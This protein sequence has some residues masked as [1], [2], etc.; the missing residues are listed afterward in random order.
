MSNVLL[1]KKDELNHG[2]L[3]HNKIVCTFYRI[4]DYI[5]YKLFHRQAPIIKVDSL[6]FINLGLIGDLI[7]FRYVIQD[8]LH[9]DYK[10]DILVREE[11][12][13]LFADVHSV[14]LVGIKNYDEKKFLSSFIKI[15]RVLKNQ[16]KRYNI[17]CHFRAYLGT[18]IVA[19]YIANIADRQIGYPT[20][21]FGFLL[22]NVIEWKTGL[23]ETKHYLQLLKVI[24][25]QY[26][27]INLNVFAKYQ[28]VPRQILDKYKL[29]QNNYIVVHATSQ[30]AAKN[31]PP[32]VLSATV[33]YL[34]AKRQI[35]VFVGTIEEKSYISDNLNSVLDQKLVVYTYGD[36]SL[37]DVD[38]LIA[39]AKLFIGIDSSI[40]HLAS[41]HNLPKIVLW[42]RL[43]IL[44]QWQPLGL[45]Y[46]IIKVEGKSSPLDNNIVVEQIEQLNIL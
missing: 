20:S 12:K 26:N 16:S 9:R 7:L 37:F 23:H 4:I 33:N 10:I 32:N 40:A 2:Y 21:G 45:N 39:T 43:N 17:A 15:I 29:L 30:N 35:V 6:L 42:H 8:F 18:G 14:N 11:Y 13:F 31:I 28:T 38:N 25:P 41:R 5:G 24:D 19:T 3:S 1:K 46:Y 36:L 34:I 22:S 27:S 44:T